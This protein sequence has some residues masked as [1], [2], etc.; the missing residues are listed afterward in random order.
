MVF[1]LLLAHQLTDTLIQPYTLNQLCR[2]V[3]PRCGVVTRFSE[4]PP[5]SMD[6]IHAIGLILVGL[7]AVLR[8]SHWWQRRDARGKPSGSLLRQRFAQLQLRRRTLASSLVGLMG[9]ALTIHGQLR[10]EPLLISLYLFG[11]IFLTCWILCLGLID[12]LA[13]RQFRQREQVD[14][15]VDEFRRAKLGPTSNKSIKT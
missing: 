10:P 2:P 11:L 7:S 4:E 12:L 3:N 13:T 9:A 5:R 6:S 8:A 15:I 14:R 1:N